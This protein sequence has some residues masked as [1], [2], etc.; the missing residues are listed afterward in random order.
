MTIYHVVVCGGGCAGLGAAVAAARS[1]ARTLLIERAPFAGGIVTAVGLPFFDGIA[2]WETNRLVV[3][4]LA[5]ETFVRL[6]VVGKDARTLHDF[7]SARRALA[8]GAAILA[9]TERFKL[10]ADDVLEE[11]GVD[12]LFHS[13]VCGVER[14]GDRITSLM[15]ANKD[16]LV[17]LSPEVVI[18]A[19]GD[20]D[21]A[22]AAGCG[23]DTSPDRMPMTMHFRIGN[24][25]PCRGQGD[26]TRAAVMDL[27]RR[28]IIPQYYGPHMSFLFAPDEAYVHA[29]RVPGDAT[30]AT[31]LSRAER[32]GRRDAFAMLDAWKAS[33]EGFED[34]Y[35]VCVGPYIGVRE[36]RRIAG[37]YLLGEEDL[38]RKTRFDDAIATGSWYTDIHPNHATAGSPHGAEGMGFMPGP[39]D[40]P[41]RSLLPR[42]VENL[43]VAGRCHSATRV[44]ASSTR[45]TATAMALGEAAGAAAA[46]AVQRRTTPTDLPGVLVREALAG[47]GGGPFTDPP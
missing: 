22:A 1:G 9:N 26:A 37:R 6:G 7:P 16:G 30:N 11:A 17:R 14:S 42:E 19:T 34:A 13:Q 12:V 32:Q 33:V 41:Y 44:A 36:T 5:L 20:A 28:G 35:M 15:V 3:R 46:L 45:V 23:M 47:L 10:I 38:R 31:D 29:V 18:D 2:C 8:H 40:I 4:G 43:L 39:Y 21:V 27:H 25:R 24:V